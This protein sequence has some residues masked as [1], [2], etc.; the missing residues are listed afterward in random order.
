MVYSSDDEP[1]VSLFIVDRGGVN[2][3]ERRGQHDESLDE[4]VDDTESISVDDGVNYYDALII[5]LFNTISGGVSKFKSDN[6]T[7]DR[8]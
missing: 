7:P 3:S 5:C 2:V 4:S 8:A 6:T 1:K